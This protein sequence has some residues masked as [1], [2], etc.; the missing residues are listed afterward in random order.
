M[1]ILL[2]GSFGIGKT[3]IAGLLVENL[4]GATIYDPAQVGFVLRRLP[5][6]MLGRFRQPDDYQD[7]RLWRLLIARGARRKHEHA[8]IVVVPMAFTNR[9]YWAAL[10][11]TLSK[12]GVVHRVCLVASLET[13]RER[14]RQRAETD[15]IAI[16]DWVIRRST[17]CVEA[18]KDRAFGLPIDAEQS[19]SEIV[20][21]IL[22]VIGKAE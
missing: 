2:N 8:A 4:Q 9:D 17:E 16:D 5:A 7:L 1:F 6:W 22:Q 21:A 19:P 20:A 18:H 11:S 12:D 13:I 15:E 10:V 3:T 14:L